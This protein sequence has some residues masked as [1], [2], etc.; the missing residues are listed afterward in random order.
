MLRGRGPCVGAACSEQGRRTNL[1][2]MSRTE[3]VALITLLL[4]ALVFAAIRGLSALSGVRDVFRRR[5]R[6]VEVFRGDYSRASRVLNTLEARG[7]PAEL[8]P[9]EQ[10]EVLVRVLS[11]SETEA[12]AIVA[13]S[14]GE[15]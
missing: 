14:Q 6:W 15:P 9:G 7:L 11:S 8:T 13:Q 3:G 12:K 4:I 5:T 1:A 2:E 10:G